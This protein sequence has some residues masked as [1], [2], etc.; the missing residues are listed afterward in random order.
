MAESD[1]ARRSSAIRSKHRQQ[2]QP[3]AA[4]LSTAG[5]LSEE[6]LPSLTASITILQLQLV[7]FL[8]DCTS[9]ASVL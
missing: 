3:S 6:Y 8:A 4:S 1:D 5:S 9:S 2:E 7:G